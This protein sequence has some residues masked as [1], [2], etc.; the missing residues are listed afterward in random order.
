MAIMELSLTTKDLSKVRYF[1]SFG[2]YVSDN[3]KPNMVA[4][5]SMASPP[6]TQQLEPQQ[7]MFA[8]G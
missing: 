3:I 6:A 1:L 7:A 2:S 4:K 5:V 8:S